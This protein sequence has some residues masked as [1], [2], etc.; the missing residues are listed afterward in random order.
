MSDYKMRYIIL[1][2]TVTL[3]TFLALD[4]ISRDLEI[5]PEKSVSEIRIENPVDGALQSTS[6][7][8]MIDGKKDA[9]TEAVNH[10]SASL[11]DRK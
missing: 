4:F 11:K 1:L 9:T 10:Q 8:K 3:F 7:K 2:I 6:L 5:H